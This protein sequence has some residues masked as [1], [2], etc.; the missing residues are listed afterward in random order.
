MRIAYCTNVRLPSERAHGHQIAQVCDALVRLGHEVTIFAPFRENSVRQSFSEYYGVD[1]KIEL[2]LLGSFDP[3]NRRMFPGVT[4][5]WVL[6]MLLRRNL[7]KALKNAKFDLLYTRSP[8]LLPA[9]LK[10]KQPVALELHQLPRLGRWCFVRR[11][12]RCRVI[13][14][15]ASPMK[16]RLIRW[17]VSAQKVIMEG[18]AVD[19]QRFASVP[20]K[21]QARKIWH[22]DT[23][24]L[25]VGYVG[26]L[27]TLAQEKGV[28]ILLHALRSLQKSQAYMGFVVGGPEADRKEY[29]QEAKELIL[30][31]DD[32]LF[33]GEIP[34]TKIP[35]ALAACDV[36]VMPFPNLPHYRQN[37]SPL[38]MFEYMA[39]QRPIVS[40]DLPTVRDVLSEKTC[41]FCKPGNV[42]SFIEALEWIREHS[43]DARK[44]A[45]EA[46]KLV[47]H[48]TWEER[49]RRILASARLKT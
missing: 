19:L 42:Q 24:R 16:E 1:K 23:D 33:T 26:R 27:K 14:C 18:D 40:S 22:I 31:S 43:E 17:G 20:S 4:A 6:N 5:L 2:K 32:V 47:L 7:K 21:E 39:A 8:P 15:L 37:M 25:V 3:I 41:V 11:C 28:G 36:L 13:A 9:L 30:T 45:E 49:M 35:T 29:E 10:S 46:R 44:C 12:R 34:A 38:K 48:Y